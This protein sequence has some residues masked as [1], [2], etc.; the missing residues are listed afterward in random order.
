MAQH[1]QK[2]SDNI[3]ENYFQLEE[4]N[5]PKTGVHV[6]I[7]YFSATFPFICHADDYELLIIEDIINIITDYLKIDND[8]VT[9]E[10]YAQNRFKYQYLLGDS[11][12]LRL[13]GPE[14]KSGYKTCMIELKGEGCR[15]FENK[16]LDKSWMDFL[17]FFVIRLNANPTR[18]DLTIDDYDGSI[19]SFEWLKQQLDLENF[20]TNFKSKKYTIHGNSV[21]GYSI[22]MGNRSSVQELVIYEK[23]KEQI[24]KGIPCNQEYWLR[25]EMRF[26]QNKAYDVSM[27]ILELKNKD[28][29]R[30]FTMERLLEIID[31]KAPGN[32]NKNNFHK[33]PTHPKWLSFLEQVNKAK[34]KR[35][36]IRKSSFETYLNFMKPKVA[37]FIVNTLLHNETDIYLSVTKLLEITLDDFEKMD[38]RKLKRYNDYLK[39]Q[40][41]KQITEDDLDALRIKLEQEIE[42]RRGLPF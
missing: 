40:N 35:Y 26:R 10:P 24:K 3:T 15:E 34:L 2:G 4:L 7:D 23:N 42:R 27:N 13:L 37:S 8:E 12:I 5:S 28:E 21:D 16:N 29:F 39:E 25:Y 22:Q 14:L 9:K 6:L 18:I 30:K 36:K 41:F 1:K 11:I 31:I 19:I 20:T 17:E 32:Y 33:L 38:E